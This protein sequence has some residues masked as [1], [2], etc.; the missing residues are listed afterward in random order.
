MKLLLVLFAVF[1]IIKFRLCNG[2]LEE[3]R[4]KLLNPT[5][6]RCRLPYE[7]NYY[8]RSDYQCP[9]TSVPNTACWRKPCGPTS[10]CGPNFKSLPFNDFEREF[11][12]ALHNGYRDRIASGQE[13]RHSGI[14]HPHKLKPANNMK[15]LQYDKELEFMAQCWSNFCLHDGWSRFHDECRRTQQFEEVGQNA[16][17]YAHI[18]PFADRI[19]FSRIA[20]L[21][22][23]VDSWFLEIYHYDD[24]RTSNYEMYF[25]T[26]NFTQ[27]IWANTSA[28][29]CGRTQYGY[30][31]VL[32]LLIYCN[33]GYAGNLAE[34]SVYDESENDTCCNG[35]DGRYVYYLT[36]NDP[37]ALKKSISSVLAL[38]AQELRSRGHDVS[39]R[40]KMKSFRTLFMT[41]CSFQY[42]CLCG[43]K[44]TINQS[45]EDY[46][47]AFKI[48][49]SNHLIAKI[50]YCLLMPWWIYLWFLSP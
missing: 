12:L 23:A 44:L 17:L 25:K 22:K 32:R 49:R 10:T 21:G 2:G 47:Q 41:A 24:R 27:L 45:N 18:T 3:V 40:Y 50:D 33:Y 29:G 35:C 37:E 30:G 8:C 28:V 43:R 5:K 46:R 48:S 42:P 20:Y 1:V 31:R 7:D 14:S 4:E 9:T 16:F 36:E 19:N 13:E 38:K 15:I 6:G 11:M 34:H 26:S 39:K